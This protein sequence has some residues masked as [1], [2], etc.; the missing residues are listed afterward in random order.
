[1]LRLCGFASESRS[2]IAGTVAP[3]KKITHSLL[4][5]RCGAKLALSGRGTQA[6]QQAQ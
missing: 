3:S 6:N 5:S 1:V 2:F 4:R